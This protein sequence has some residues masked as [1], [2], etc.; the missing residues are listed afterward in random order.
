MK[1]NYFIIYYFIG[2][3]SIHAHAS[4]VE[5]INEQGNRVVITQPSKISWSELKGTYQKKNLSNLFNINIQSCNDIDINFKSKTS[6]YQNILYNEYGC[7]L[8]EDKMKKSLCLKMIK[9]NLG[10]LPKEDSMTLLAA[11]NGLFFEEFGFWDEAK[12]YAN[13]V[14]NNLQECEIYTNKALLTQKLIPV[15]SKSAANYVKRKSLA[16]EFNSVL[17]EEKETAEKYS[18]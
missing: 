4:T 5:L 14:T 18:D 3:L 9:P 16:N 15:N 17:E 7:E 11:S 6:F 2:F 10:Y 13:K 1:T 8:Y 12:E